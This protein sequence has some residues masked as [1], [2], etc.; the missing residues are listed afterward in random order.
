M[1]H[2]CRIE[3]EI[4]FQSK[5]NRAAAR[6]L[7]RGQLTL[8]QLLD[9]ATFFPWM[10]TEER[11]PFSLRKGFEVPAGVGH[12]VNLVKRIREIR[13]P[14]G[15]RAH[16]QS[17]SAPGRTEKLSNRLRMLP[18]AQRELQLVR[19]IRRQSVDRG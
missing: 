19:F 14:G 6:N 10:Q 16:R 1:T 8:L 18:L 12:P 13:H 2:E 17:V 7:E 4:F 3:G 11:K 15:R 5:G 9:G